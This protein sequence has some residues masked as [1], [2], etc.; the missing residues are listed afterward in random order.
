MTV[1]MYKYSMQLCVNRQHSFNMFNYWSI[2][3]YYIGIF[4]ALK[5][6]WSIVSKF[7]I[8]LTHGVVTCYF[9]LQVKYPHVEAFSSPVIQ[10]S[11]TKISSVMTLRCG[12]VT[13][14]LAMSTQYKGFPHL[15]RAFPFLLMLILAQHLFSKPQGCQ[16]GHP[17]PAA[18]QA[19]VHHTP[20]SS[21]CM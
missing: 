17:N 20:K 6:L 3:T 15:T 19:R 8:R 7:V 21:F 11:S 12:P 10:M 13:V 2:Y 1:K 14:T 4:V 5:V 9:P 16:H 18:V